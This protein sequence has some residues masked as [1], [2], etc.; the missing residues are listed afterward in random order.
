MF[1]NPA[2]Q[3]CFGHLLLCQFSKVELVRHTESFLH[4]P[5]IKKHRELNLMVLPATLTPREVK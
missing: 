3:I 2:H 1:S 5:N 4:R